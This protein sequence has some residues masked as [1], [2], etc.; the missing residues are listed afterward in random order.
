MRG[1]F[2]SMERD[3]EE[4]EEQVKQQVDIRKIRI[5]QLQLTTL[6]KRP[7]GKVPAGSKFSKS[8]ALSVILRHLD[9]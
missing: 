9:G 1:S 6:Q 2:N 7:N 3:P 8:S 5:D 4:L